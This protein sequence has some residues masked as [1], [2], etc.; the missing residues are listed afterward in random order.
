MVD[1]FGVALELY[2]ITSNIKK[3]GCGV[4]YGFL[5]FLMKYKEKNAHNMFFLMLDPRFKNLWLVCFLLVNSKMFPFVEDHDR[6][7]LFPMLLKCH[8]VPHLLVE[9]KIVANQ[10]SCL[11]IFKIIVGTN[12]PTKELVNREL[13]MF[14]WYQVD[15]KN[16]KCLLKW[17]EKH[18][19]LFSIV[20]FLTNRILGIVKI[21]NWN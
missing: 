21:S 17:W 1:S 15:T 18:E 2:M 6:C 20:I 16:T 11:Y 3:E 8:H 5:S 19:S 10:D 12:E 4:L 9:S 7:Y 13:K 14:K